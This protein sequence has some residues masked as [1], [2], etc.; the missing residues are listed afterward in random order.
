[1]KVSYNGLCRYLPSLG[2]VTETARILT[3]IGLEVDS[4]TP[5]G[6][7]PNQGE[8]L[9][10]GQVL[11]CEKHPNADRLQL[12]RVDV[13]LPEPLSIVCGAPN[14]AAGQRVVVATVGCTLYPKGG[15]PFTIR[16]SKLRGEVSEGMLCSAEEIGL[17]QDHEGILILPEQAQVGA[18]VRDVLGDVKDYIIE[19][20]LTANRADAM[21]HYGVARD[22]SVYL[23]FHGASD[24]D[25]SLHLPD[26]S[27]PPARGKGD[28]TPVVLGS[29]DEA[30]CIRYC[31]L[32]IEGVTNGASPA[33]LVEALAGLGM[34]S[35]N[36]VVDIT[37][38][39]L[40]AL[41]Q[42]LH[43]FDRSFFTNN[44]VEVRCFP[45][46]TPF[47][48]LEG[49][50]RALQ[51][52]DLLI[53]C[54][55]TPLCLA[56][57]LGGENSGVREST[58]SLFLEA[59]VFEPTSIRKSAKHHGIATD[60][61]FRFE[62]GVD[63]T[64]TPKALG[65]AARLI[66]ELCGGRVVGE[67][68]D[69]YPTPWSHREVK[70]DLAR[71]YALMGLTVEREQLARLF[72]LLEMKSTFCDEGRSVVLQ[73]PRY[74][75]DVVSLEDVAEEVLRHV[76][77]DSVPIDDA[78]SFHLPLPD[79]AISLGQ[80]EHDVV[81]V[82]MGMGFTE[83]KSLSFT[84]KAL[85]S[86]LPL[87]SDK[88]LVHLLNPLSSDLDTLRSTLLW[89]MLD[90]VK[91]NIAHQRSDLRLFEL[92]NIFFQH[93][94]K[95]ETGLAQYEEC[96]RLGL[97]CC[98]HM[99]EEHWSETLHSYSFFHVKGYVATLLAW[100]GIPMCDVQY[101]SAPTG[102]YQEGI[103]IQ[104]RDRVVAHLGLLHSALLQRGG[105]KEPVYYAELMWDVL[106]SALETKEH[107][108]Q[109]LPKYPEVRRDLSMLLN[110]D[111][112][113]FDIERLAFREEPDLLIRVSL[114]DV[115]EGD[116]LPAGKK[117]YAVSF[118]LQDRHSTLDDKRIDRTMKRL[119]STYKKELGAELR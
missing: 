63:P 113:F 3:Q 32:T 12:T 96:T 35:V 89:G 65:Y 41:G 54:G 16:K 34:H 109:A 76:G 4:V 42:P 90:A 99:T 75:V 91:R 14:V 15:D 40:H 116:N 5:I 79:G 9:R 69:W 84:S 67:M 60:A 66:V 52:E 105:V 47:V 73:V 101:V 48:T 83:V 107:C 33:W 93:L 70:V 119:I 30:R 39:V 31:G 38:Y 45:A 106:I 28:E 104:W 37:N 115:Y 80:V 78:V 108:V 56:G 26:F 43:A 23:N 110:K 57:V 94:T 59:A 55:D 102:Y 97:M 8:G 24:A 1:M 7:L 118:I 58:T 10:V 61:S 25:Y 111:V 117:S 92:G 13:G 21:S 98:G 74:R 62:R 81:R 85:S 53:S 17:S 68:Q 100:F 46:G 2:S 86:S 50:E 20:G 103:A 29:I 82:L 27:L 18:P 87:P 19:I 36:R 64:F 6:G 71:L 44:Q 112:T 51:A 11:T 22:L 114:F 49:K 95:Q 77:Y 88:G 72:T